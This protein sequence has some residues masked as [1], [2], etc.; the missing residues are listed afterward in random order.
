MGSFWDSCLFIFFAGWLLA[1][2]GVIR[3]M[4]SIGIKP[5]EVIA[6]HRRGSL[7]VEGIWDR[8]GRHWH[9]PNSRLV[10]VHLRVNE[11]VFV[12][13]EPVQVQTSEGATVI[14]TVR[15][16]MDVAA[17]TARYVIAVV[18][19]VVERWKEQTLPILIAQ[20]TSVF[21]AE[22]ALNDRKRVTQSIED[23]VAEW[24]ANNSIPD[25]GL[26]FRGAAITGVTRPPV[27][28]S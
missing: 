2:G 19:K 3:M 23:K 25:L 20:A 6:F 26:V 10:W 18:G 24:F 22:Q 4:F 28:R 9:L 12:S 7:Q 17:P 14:L 11:P 8:P 16:T 5:G 21:S 13:S 1:V 15:L 27:P